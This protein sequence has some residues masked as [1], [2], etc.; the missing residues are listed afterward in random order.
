[1]E[2]LDASQDSELPV[3]Q[4]NRNVI[5]A[6]RVQCQRK[7]KLLKVSLCGAIAKAVRSSLIN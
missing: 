1:V 7:L 5:V 3:V 4:D 6:A 2:K